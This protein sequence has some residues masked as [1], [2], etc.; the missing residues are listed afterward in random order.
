VHSRV[1]HRQSPNRARELRERAWAVVERQLAGK[2][3]CATCGAT[4]ATIDDVCSA[5]L[6]Q[7]CP[8]LDA[9]AAIFT[10]EVRKAGLS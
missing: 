9:I 2:V 5:D 1:A 10:A 4:A 8:G 6:D 7:R 3:I